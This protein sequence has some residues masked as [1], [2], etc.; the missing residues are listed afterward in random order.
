MVTRVI[1]G[2]GSG[3]NPAKP[4]Q[5][6]R[7]GRG[8][9]GVTGGAQPKK[10]TTEQAK[11]ALI[12]YVG[13]GYNITAA[14][15]KIGYA[16]KT[17]ESWRAK[18]EK[19]K[20]AVDSV[21]STRKVDTGTR[22]E[23]RAAARAMG[24]AAWSEKYLNTP[25]YPHAQQWIDVLEGREPSGLHPA[26]T[27]EVSKPTRLVVNTFPNAGKSTTLTMNYVTY[28]ICINP[29]TKIALISK[30]EG[31]AKDFVAGVKTRLTHPDHIDLIRDFAPEGGFEAT[32]DEW[33]TGRI[34][35][36]AADRDPAD[37]D[38]TLQALGL[39][40]QVYGKRLDL[41]LVDDAVD[42]ENAQQWRTQLRWLNLEVASRPG[43]SGRIVVIGT[44]I[45]A[46]DL[47][48]Q[49]R[50]GEN[51]QS[52]KSPWS[53]LSQP[54]L[55]EDDPDHTKWVTLWP[56][57]KTSWW[58]DDDPCPCGQDVCKNGYGDGTY[59]RL[60]PV[61]LKIV[62]ESV[63]VDTWN[64]AYMQFDAGSDA[65]FPA[66]ALAAATNKA[67]RHGRD[68]G[69]Q[70]VPEGMYV[71]GSCDP[72]TAGAAAFVVGAVDRNTGKRWIYDAWNVKHPT[73][74]DLKERLKAITLEFG[75]REWRIEKTGLLTMFTRDAELNQWFAAR[76]VLLRE[77]YTGKNKHDVDFGVG[78]MA[79]LFGVYMQD[80]NGD[81]H[82]VAEPLI[83][84][85]RNEGD[86]ATL[87]KQ[88]GI[89]HPEIDPKKTPIDLV[90]ALWFFDIGCRDHIRHA[91]LSARKRRHNGLVSLA[92]RRRAGV[93][94]LTHNHATPT[95]AVM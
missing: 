88:L 83:E 49:L 53:Y 45:T 27:W 41:I 24:F 40:S 66:H 7:A 62:R 37:K 16:R 11:A 70:T 73:P 29:A 78:S 74:H 1:K 28:R 59:P 39:G 38:P 85:P 5:G 44:R 6:A 86:I 63:D 89:W 91:D 3:T 20:A 68:G 51:F 33:S 8:R 36:S 47:Y 34:R 46:G 77:H 58:T 64:Q 75:V 72:A 42:N 84:L 22:D 65:T 14:C 48:S 57:A 92:D 23:K 69:M 12:D 54:V 21:M 93:R 32:S 87:V 71:I 25:V 13:A 9:G 43:M 26:Q 17:Y 19:F 61:H 15:D 81:Q 35:L 94:Q 50:I 82:T 55:L 56:K 52:G 95:Q 31:M 4:P 60:D 30:T 80:E 79:P 67:R 90:M 2:G 18:D 76:G 10:F